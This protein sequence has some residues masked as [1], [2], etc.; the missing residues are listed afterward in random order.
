MSADEYVGKLCTSFKRVTDRIQERTS[1]LQDFTPA[2]L[3]EGKQVFVD[4]LSF[5]VDQFTV[6]SDD[7]DA[8]GTPDVPGA[9]DSIAEV[10][11]KFVS[12]TAIL[13][14][15]LNQAK[16]L[17]TDDPT[18]FTQGIEGI[19]AAIDRSDPF[20]GDD[21]KFGQSELDAAYDANPTCQALNEGTSASPSP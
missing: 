1:S 21:V 15:A 17:P 7:L 6:M 8:L 12:A 11:T 16:D 4:Y 14:T 2:T 19:T 3:E 13:Q 9:A 10:K 5:V 18:A 20:G